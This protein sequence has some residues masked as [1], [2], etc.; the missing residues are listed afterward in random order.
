MT[1]GWGY[2][3]EAATTAQGYITTCMTTHEGPSD[4][5]FRGCNMGAV[6]IKSFNNFQKLKLPV[7][8]TGKNI[9][10]LFFLTCY[11]VVCSFSKNSMHPSNMMRKK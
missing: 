6:N 4:S 10:I 8:L 11:V 5:I 3:Y 7:C 1:L 9:I 2:V